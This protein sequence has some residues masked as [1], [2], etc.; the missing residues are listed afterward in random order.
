MCSS[1]LLHP[2]ATPAIVGRI[3]T[4]QIFIV[5][6]TKHT[7]RFMVVVPNRKRV[8]PD[9]MGAGPVMGIM[10]NTLPPLPFT[11]ELEPFMEETGVILFI[12]Y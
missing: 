1:I 4:L 2:V 7:R 11:G 12:V 10:K 9:T 5:N 6:R 3:F 8:N